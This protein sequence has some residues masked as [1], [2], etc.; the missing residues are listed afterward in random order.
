MRCIVLC[1]DVASF[2]VSVVVGRVVETTLSRFVSVLYRHALLKI[3][4]DQHA[5]K[6]PAFTEKAERVLKVT[7][8]SSSV[9]FNLAS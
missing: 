3:A 8:R 9:T 6:P 5:T 1:H 7:P 4:D 2:S